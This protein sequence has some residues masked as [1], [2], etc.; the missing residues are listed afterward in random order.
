[1]PCRKRARKFDKGLPTSS[2]ETSLLRGKGILE[3]GNPERKRRRDFPARHM[4]DNLS[5]VYF[6]LPTDCRED[7]KGKEK[8]GGMNPATRTSPA[9][10]G[11]GDLSK[12]V[13]GRKHSLGRCSRGADFAKQSDL[14]SLSPQ[15]YFRRNRENKKQIYESDSKPD[16]YGDT[17]RSGKRS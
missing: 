7:K 14:L 12:G 2:A 5:Q 1:M 16:L 13:K 3:E 11:A 10:G 8:G 15:R 9:K 17:R 4:N 6:F